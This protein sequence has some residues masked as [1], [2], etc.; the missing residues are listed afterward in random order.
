MEPVLSVPERQG[1]K[2]ICE[3]N[4]CFYED[5]SI[6]FIADGEKMWVNNRIGQMQ[7]SA[8]FDYKDRVYH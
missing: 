7:Y 6:V 8:L 5:G 4:Y 1:I 2:R 3:K